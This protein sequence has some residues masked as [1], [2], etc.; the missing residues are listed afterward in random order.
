MTLSKHQR[1]LISNACAH[2]NCTPELRGVLASILMTG[3][4]PRDAMT[5]KDDSLDDSVWSLIH[6]E[7]A[8]ACMSHPEREVC[9]RSVFRAL[10]YIMVVSGTLPF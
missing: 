7:I 6:Y 9:L 3:E 2:P 8:I 4:L 10:E 5:W 1:A